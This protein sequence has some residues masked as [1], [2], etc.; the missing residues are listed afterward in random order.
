MRKIKKKTV[1]RFFRIVII[2]I[3]VLIV[4]FPIYWILLTST[5]SVDEILTFPPKFLPNLKTLSLKHYI[6][7]LSGRI[8]S[9]TNQYGVPTFFLNSVIICVVTTVSTVF[10]SLFAA[11]S[12]VRGRFRG[13]KLVSHLILF[14]YLIPTVTLMIPMF[15]MAVKM[16]INNTLI[17][18]IIFQI[19]MNLP[20]GIWFAKSFI[21]GIPETLEE[22]AKLDGCSRIQ[23]VSRVIFPLSVPGLVVVGFNTFLASWN[24]Y[25]LPSILIDKENLKPLMVGLYLYFNQNIGII[26]GEAMASA[27]VTMIPVFFVFFYFQKFIVSGLTVGAVKG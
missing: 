5:R 19:A 17:G 25:L 20:L 12:L 1:G 13:R 10:L 18:V 22:A 11:Y 7:V 16:H 15:S 3:V 26:W 24:D 8:G 6:A 4:I 21:Q 27:V 2:W 23:I 14:C 9:S